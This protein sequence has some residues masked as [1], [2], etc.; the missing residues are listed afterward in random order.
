MPPTAP[1]FACSAR[2]FIHEIRRNGSYAH[3]AQ[4]YRRDVRADAFL[5]APEHT[6]PRSKML[7]HAFYVLVERSSATVAAISRRQCKVNK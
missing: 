4:P 2:P 3:Y 5:P 7:P 1:L 6:P